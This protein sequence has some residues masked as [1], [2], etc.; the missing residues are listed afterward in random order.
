MNIYTIAD[1][2]ARWISCPI[3]EAHQHVSDFGKISS[4]D[5]T[6]VTVTLEDGTKGYGEAK[7]AVGSMGSC[8]SLALVIEREL[9]PQLVGQDARQIN[10]IW[11]LLYNGSRQGYAEQHGRSFHV[12]GRRGLW[13]SAMSGIDL[14]LWDLAGKRLNSPVLDIIGGPIRDR[15]NGYASGGWADAGNI[16]TQLKSYVDRGF[17]AVKMRIGVMDDTVSNSVAR[18][19]AARAAVG[20]DIDIMVDAHGTYN[21]AE[22]R[23]F[24]RRT[25]DLNL[26]WFE[27][28]VSAD[29]RKAMTNIRSHTSMPISMGESE[30][31]CFDFQDLI[32]RDAAD[33]LQPDMAICGGFSEGL[34]ISALAVSNQLELAPHC[35]GSAFSFVAGLTLGFASPAA[36]VIEFSLGANPLLR[37]LVQENIDAEDGSF[38]PPAGAGW[39]LTLNED[40]VSEF[41]R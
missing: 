37:D 28:P 8:D 22:A 3:P 40:F 11:S 15:M 1:V 4:F 21:G 10:R 7:A 13:I 32:D 19:T 34:K 25:E 18:V 12:L 5:M 24:S 16:G 9:K 41:G 36:K 27:E 6:L 29:S 20:P 35:W 33:I 30:F 23:E 31:T 14:A 39:G 17:K 26:R 2:E 38:E